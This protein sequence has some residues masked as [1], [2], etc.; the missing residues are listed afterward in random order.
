MTIEKTLLYCFNVI[1][2]VCIKS[3]IHKQPHCILNVFCTN[4]AL[5]WI[6]SHA[7]R[8]VDPCFCRSEFEQR[9]APPPW[10][11]DSLWT[12][13]PILQQNCG[14]ANNTAWNHARKMRLHRMNYCYYESIQC[15]ACTLMPGHSPH[16]NV[17]W[18]D[19]IRRTVEA[20][21]STCDNKDI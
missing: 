15:R 14:G 21:W 11:R 4:V 5:K 16:L 1:Y 8:I 12:W 17:L 3:W 6:E 13:T 10:W 19:A 7:I 20:D 9:I 18:W 2:N